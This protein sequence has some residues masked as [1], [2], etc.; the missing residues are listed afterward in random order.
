M[1]TI[2]HAGAVVGRHAGILLTSIICTSIGFVIGATAAQM[3][4]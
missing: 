4:P 2:R 3:T 1:S